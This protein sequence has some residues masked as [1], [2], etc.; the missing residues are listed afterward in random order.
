MAAVIADEL[1]ADLDVTMARKI[2]APRNPEF[3]IGAIADGGGP[4][5]NHD[6]IER[7]GIP[8]LYVEQAVA[9]A[10]AELAR[11]TAAYRHGRKPQ[12]ATQRT[13]IV[14]DDGVATGSTLRAVLRAVR[15]RDPQRLVCAVPVGPP[16]TIGALDAEADAVVCPLTPPGFIAVG[17]WYEDFSQLDDGDV[18][19]ILDAH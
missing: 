15:S 8:A 14:A 12:S 1:D 19:A 3:A 4:M 17:A 7:H 9:K 5:L 10:S 2:G 16:E 13:V 6:V 11:R 18:V